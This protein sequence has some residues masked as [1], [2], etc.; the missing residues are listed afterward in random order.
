MLF[1]SRVTWRL[2]HGRDA[3]HRRVLVQTVFNIAVADGPNSITIGG[4]TTSGNSGISHNNPSTQTT[5]IGS[6]NGWLLRLNA[7]TGNA[8]WSRY[9]NSTSGN[10]NTIY[11]VWR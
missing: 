1:V 8:L 4:V 10:S 3:T 2:L 7:T 9:F 6:S 11:Y 5:L